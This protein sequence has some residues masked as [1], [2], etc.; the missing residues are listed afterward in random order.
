MPVRVLRV[1]L[2]R[3]ILQ[4]SEVR[5]QVVSVDELGSTMDYG[6]RNGLLDDD[7]LR[8]FGGKTHVRSTTREQLVIIPFSLARA[9]LEE[10]LKISTAKALESFDGGHAHAK[11]ESWASDAVLP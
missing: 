10:T 6:V 3:R 4:V 1:F 8:G 11:E 9:S 2:I 7:P 5:R